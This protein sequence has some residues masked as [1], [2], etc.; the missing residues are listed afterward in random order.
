MRLIRREHLRERLEKTGS[1]IV[2]KQNAVLTNRRGGRP[3]HGGAFPHGFFGDCVDVFRFV[4]GAKRNPVFRLAVLLKHGDDVGHGDFAL[5]VGLKAEGVVDARGSLYGYNIA[6]HHTLHA[7]VERFGLFFQRKRKLNLF[8]FAL[9][10]Q[11]N[12]FFGNGLINAF[13][14]HGVFVVAFNG[15]RVVHGA[16]YKRLRVIERLGVG[17]A[18]FA[19]ELY[20]EVQPRLAAYGV[21]VKRA[22][23]RLHLKLLLLGK[24]NLRR[25][26]AAFEGMFERFV[27]K[28]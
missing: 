26:A 18:V 3:E 13:S 1:R 17:I 5:F 22:V 24:V 28:C 23:K 19:V 9:L 10:H 7:R 21:F 15:A 20:P 8:T 11:R 27:P 12:F 6:V 25:T 16:L 14:L 4:V 2:A